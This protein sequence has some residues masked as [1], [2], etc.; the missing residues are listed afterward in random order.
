MKKHFYYLAFMALFVAA[1]QSISVTPIAT[2]T[3]VS[4]P[5]ITLTSTQIVATTTYD[6]LP[7]AIH[8]ITTTPSSPQNL[9]STPTETPCFDSRPVIHEELGN[10][11]ETVLSIPVGEGSIIKYDRHP[12]SIQGPIAIAILR[13]DSFLLSD[14]VADRLLHYDRLGHLLGTIELND[15]GIANIRDLRVK[16]N[17]LFLLEVSYQKF[18][19][20][21]LSLDGALIASDEIP[22]N[23]PIDVK[24]KDYTLENGLTGIAIDCEGNVLLEVT[25]GTKLF[26]LSDVQNQSEPDNIVQGYICDDKRYRVTTT[27]P[28][29]SPK[30]SAGD[31]IY[32]TGLTHGFGGLNFLDV[33]SDGSFY[34]VRSDVVTESVI[35][36]DQTVHYIDADGTVLGLARVPLSEFY[37]PIMRNMAISATGEVFVL[38]PRPDTIDIIRLNFYKELEPLVPG[39]VIP[40][41]IMVSNNP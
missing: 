38:L 28:S 9:T 1:C 32:E 17:E 7:A 22:Y 16:E 35:T 15:L 19:V 18:R 27:D 29:Q 5:K 34:V 3:L 13:D 10:I 8:P 24:E 25:G 26:P 37:Y 12:D 36:V 21:H 23:F 30:I 6:N 20:H 33:F 11:Y 40:K 41:I 2:P 4:S 14:F 31:V 39:A